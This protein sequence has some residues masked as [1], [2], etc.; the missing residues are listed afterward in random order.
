MREE[1]GSQIHRIMHYPIN[2]ETAALAEAILVEDI[3]RSL[4]HLTLTDIRIELDEHN[5]ALVIHL[6]FD[7]PTGNTVT[8][9]LRM[10]NGALVTGDGDKICQN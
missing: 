1:F 7:T 8:T 5:A 6:V 9:K 3:R 4:P 10:Q 2:E